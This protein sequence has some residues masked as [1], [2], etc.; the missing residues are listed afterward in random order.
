[1]E[2]I[3]MNGFMGLEKNKYS[4]FNTIGILETYSP[5]TDFFIQKENRF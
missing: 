3:W 1:M 4:N 2:N 5:N